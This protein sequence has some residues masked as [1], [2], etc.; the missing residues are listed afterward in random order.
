MKLS[1]SLRRLLLQSAAFAVSGFVLNISASSPAL[2]SGDAAAGKTKS[3]TCTACHGQD[4][5]GT[6]SEFPILAGQYASYLEQALIQY[7]NGSRKN[8]IMAGFAAGLSEQDIKDLAAFYSAMP[9]GL[10]T[11]KP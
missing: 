10:G 7:K 8:A 4:G 9:S 5:L 2:A 6:A 11:P 1:K 3:A